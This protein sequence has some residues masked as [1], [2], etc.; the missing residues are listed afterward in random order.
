MEQPVLHIGL[1]VLACLGLAGW[2]LSALDAFGYASHMVE[3][4]SR[5]TEDRQEN[6]TVFDLLSSSLRL[7]ADGLDDADEGVHGKQAVH[8]DALLMPDRN[9]S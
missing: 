7:L 4:L 5:L 6:Q 2:A 1:P 3:I 9:R 8:R